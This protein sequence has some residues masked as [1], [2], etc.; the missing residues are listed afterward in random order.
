METKMLKCNFFAVQ[1]KDLFNTTTISDSKKLSRIL[2]SKLVLWRNGMKRVMCTTCCKT[3]CAHRSKERD[4]EFLH[5]SLQA[6][7]IRE[8]AT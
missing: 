4:I 3:L 8:K 2:L 1:R 7:L 5:S 6:Y